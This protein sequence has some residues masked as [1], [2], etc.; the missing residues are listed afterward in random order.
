MGEQEIV[1]ERMTHILDGLRRATPELEAADLFTP[2]GKHLFVNLKKE[3]HRLSEEQPA[4][5]PSALA[6]CRI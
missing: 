5:H 2:M 6:T 1:S 4:A 3:V